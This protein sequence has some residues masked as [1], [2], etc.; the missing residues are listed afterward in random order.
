MSVESTNYISSVHKL[1]EYSAKVVKEP[2]F[3]RRFVKTKNWKEAL[4]AQNDVL[5]MGAKVC[6]DISKVALI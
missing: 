4:K 1:S 3:L 6:N 5:R 2:P